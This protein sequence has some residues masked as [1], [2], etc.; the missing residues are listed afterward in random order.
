MPGAAPRGSP[1]EGGGPGRLASPVGRPYFLFPA[2]MWPSKNHRRVLQAFRQFVASSDT[3]MELVLTGDPSG[4]AAIAPEAAGLPVRHLGF[5]PDE[6]MAALYRG[7][8]ALLFLSLLEGFGLPILEALHHGIPVLGSD[9]GSVP[10]VAGAAMLVCD[11]TDVGAMATAMQAIASDARLR[12]RLVGLG[13]LRLAAY[14]WDRSAAA[15]RAA[16]GRVAHR[17]RANARPSSARWGR[18]EGSATRAPEL[19]IVIPLSAHRGRAVEAVDSAACRQDWP[20]GDLEVIVVTDGADRALDGQVKALL[21]AGDRLIR[22]AT[23][24]GVELTDLGAR[25]ARGRILFVVEGHCELAPTV[26]RELIAFFATG[27]HDA[28]CVSSTGRSANTFARMEQRYFDERFAVWRQ[29]GEWRKVMLRGFAILRSAYLDAGGLEWRYGLFADRAL[30]ATLHAGGYRVGWAERAWIVH[31]NATRYAAFRESVSDYVTGELAYLETHDADYCTRYFGRSEPWVERRDW[32]RE[33]VR[34][35]L[36]ALVRVLGRGVWPSET[37]GALEATGALAREAAGL[38]AAAWLG[39]RWPV[40]RASVAVVSA[41]LRCARPRL[42]PEGHIGPTPSCGTRPPTSRARD[43][44]APPG[45][46]RPPSRAGL[47]SAD[48]VAR[49]LPVVRLPRRRAVGVPRLPV[50]RAGRRALAGSPARPLPC[51]ARNRASPAARPAR[52][53]LA[54]PADPRRRAPR[55]H[56]PLRPGGHS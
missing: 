32:G 45:R 16:L 10:E 36:R 24:N 19:S 56:D 20:R 15:L 48:R 53:L 4:W 29:P 43:T 18:P 5:V 47:G 14:S 42:E 52:A 35:A 55:A 40:L 11:P 30:A 25:A 3:P 8:T 17:G 22:A 37:P 46:A 2:N 21:G 9:R 51:R 12:D 41:R 49:S 28:A 23:A 54:R 1:P 50:D 13:T 44:L 26:A 31:T 7:A 39:P 27:E 38:T 6:E 33:E 34:A